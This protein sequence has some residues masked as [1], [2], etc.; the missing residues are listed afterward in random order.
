MGDIV[1]M[2]TP[3]GGRSRI[4]VSA[5]GEG[6]SIDLTFERILGGE[7]GEVNVI[8]ETVLRMSAGQARTLAREILKLTGKRA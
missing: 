5:D 6:R 1:N 7:A 8:A 2:R 3:S 4:A